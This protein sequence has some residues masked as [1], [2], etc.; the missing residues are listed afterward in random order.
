MLR[1]KT[2]PGEC[3]TVASKSAQDMKRAYNA[4]IKRG[5]PHTCATNVCVSVGTLGCETLPGDH[6]PA[7]AYSQIKG[8]VK[9]EPDRVPDAELE[10]YIKAGTTVTPQNYPEFRV[11]NRGGG[12]Q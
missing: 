12:N 9:S 5:D 3:F 2:T 6:V 4:G 10:V 11:F 8:W 1:I 7:A